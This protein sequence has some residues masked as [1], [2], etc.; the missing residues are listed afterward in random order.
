M[1]GVL[2]KPWSVNQFEHYRPE[3]TQFVR[4]R[5]S[6]LI[7]S[8]DGPSRV[9]IRAPVKSGKREMVEYTAKRDESTEPVRVH[10]FVSAFHRKA[11]EDQRI[12]LASHNL[13][14]FSL[15]T[16]TS[17]DP[18]LQWI[19]DKLALGLTVVIHFDE[20]DYGSDETQRLNSI[21]KKIN[22]DP[23]VRCIFYSATPE[24]LQ[25]SETITQ[26]DTDTN[27]I[28]GVYEQG[29]M[30]HY[31]PPAGYCGASR[32]LD[33]G[34]V[35][36]ARRFFKEKD[37]GSCELSAQGKEIIAAAKNDLEMALDRQADAR[38]AAR[39]ALNGGN[40]PEFERQM[41]IAKAPIRNIIA[42][43]LSYD[44]KSKEDGTQRV[45]RKAIYQFLGHVDDFPELRDTSVIV[46]K[47]ELPEGAPPPASRVELSQI[48][49]SQPAYWN[50]LTSDRIIIVVMD[51]TSSRSTEWAF[52][53]RCSVEHD[54]RPNITFAVVAQAQL[55]AAHYESR[56]GGFQPIRVYGHLKTWMFADE[57]ISVEE[58]MNNRWRVKKNNKLPTYRIVDP[59]NR[60]HPRYNQSVTLSQ[61]NEIMEELGCDSKVEL[62]SRIRGGTRRVPKVLHDFEPCTSETFT[63]AITAL[64]SRIPHIESNN[65]NS[66]FKEEHR[67]PEGLY[68]CPFRGEWAVREYPYF[69][70]NRWGFSWD[71]TGPRIGVCYRNGECGIAIR[72]TNGEEE[73]IDTLETYR[74][75]YVINNDGQ[76]DVD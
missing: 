73:F 61:A 38:T 1:S 57:R 26:D 22:K 25:W 9:L 59:L 23:R 70:K 54:Y 35:K 8:N 49:W 33:G 68:E 67:T 64:K 47:A 53:N 39:K 37:D 17:T 74:S 10:A 12:E 50:S 66:P 42:L 3:L 4:T 62:S 24:E 32:F 40:I 30:V 51:Q 2:S 48:K 45:Q 56:Y 72:Y 20:A 31:T 7:E 55:R 21:W 43:R 46:D 65:F 19:D 28:A 41:A 27:F 69:F 34:H 29:V 13:T 75:M 44:S 63:H 76:E 52:H 6:P 16:K 58:Y 11:D 15:S 5:V 18:I 14:V 71:N 60:I 36:D